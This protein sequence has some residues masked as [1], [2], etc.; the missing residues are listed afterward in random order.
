MNADDSDWNAADMGLEGNGTRL[1][2]EHVCEYEHRIPETELDQL[3]GDMSQNRSGHLQDHVLVT[4]KRCCPGYYTS[5]G[6]HCVESRI[7]NPF[8]EVQFSVA[9]GYLA[10]L[11]IAVSIVSILIAYR[12]H[13]R[14]SW[15]STRR[16]KILNNCCE[17]APSSS[18]QETSCG[19]APNVK[20]QS[21][22][23][24]VRATSPDFVQQHDPPESG[25]VPRSSSTA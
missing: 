20:L 1:T 14:Y 7:G 2:G 12:Y 11:L 5:D 16:H 17:E 3:V 4:I 18:A 24:E 6:V 21:T 15:R 23:V 8:S 9:L 13:Y 19:L 25:D 10:I 22:H